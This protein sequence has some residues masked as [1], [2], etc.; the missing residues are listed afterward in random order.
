MPKYPREYHK[1][2]RGEIKD[3]FNPEFKFDSRGRLILPLPGYSKMMLSTEPG[4]KNITQ[5]TESEAGTPQTDPGSFDSG[6]IYSGTALRFGPKGGWVTQLSG[7]DYEFPLSYFNEITNVMNFYVDKSGNVYLKGTIIAEAGGI[8]GGWTIGATELYAGAGANRV[9]LKP[10]TWPFYAGAVDPSAA[11]FRVNPAGAVWC[12]SLNI[13]GGTG[14]ANLADAGSLALLNQANLDTHVAEGTTY[15]RT[16]A[17]ALDANGLVLLDQVIEGTYKRVL[18]TH[19]SAGKIYIFSDTQFAAGYNPTEKERTV[20]KQSTAPPSPAAGDLWIDTSVAPNLWKRWTGSA[21]I[22][23]TPESSDINALL[24]INAPAQAG[25]DVTAGKSL[26]VLTDTTLAFIA[27]T[28]TWKKTTANEKIGASLGY[29]ILFSKLT[30]YGLVIWTANSTT[31]VELTASGLRGYNAG[32]LQVEIKASDG[33]IYAGAGAVV[34]DAVGVR[35]Y[36]AGVERFRLVAD[37]LNFYDA[38][39][40][41]HGIIDASTDGL[42]ITSN[43]DNKYID[44]F[45]R[46]VSGVLGVRVSVYATNTIFYG[47]VNPGTGGPWNLGA[48][49]TGAGWD[50]LILANTGGILT[51]GRASYP[52]MKF[53]EIGTTYVR[54]DCNADF[55]PATDN[56]GQLGYDTQR[57]QRVRA[58]SVVQGDSIFQ[59]KETREDLFRISEDPNFLNFYNKK[60]QLIMKLN[61]EGELYVKKI[62]EKNDL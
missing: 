35:G 54:A 30:A 59:D 39:G 57:W 44:L 8:I 5:G 43:F 11:S 40:N 56:Q 46:N 31:R 2:Q 25:A 7:G 14:V 47:H 53:T 37:K 34:L 10:G 51:T 27:D 24:T 60:G 41:L 28:V 15:K 36:S 55:V 52:A 42:K 9:G 17:V 32:V 33:K 1:P 50:K 3:P 22:K 29:D 12:S 6:Y 23:A 19:I 45:T 26:S 49:L 62:I 48:P 13:L 61:Q 4:S 20:F 16:K 38:S 58:V 21:W 18:A